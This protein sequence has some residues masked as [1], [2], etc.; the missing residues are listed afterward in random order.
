ML[1]LRNVWT[2]CEV[3]L[4]SLG[5]LDT[6]G[7]RDVMFRWRVP[8]LVLM[9]IRL[10]GSFGMFTLRRRNLALALPLSTWVTLFDRWTAVRVTLVT[11]TCLSVELSMEWLSGSCLTTWL[12][13]ACTGI[14]C[15]TL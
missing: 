3:R 14:S 13:P 10:G 5:T 9:L 2:K 6:S 15:G 7:H 4:P 1:T 8:Y 12:A 11:L